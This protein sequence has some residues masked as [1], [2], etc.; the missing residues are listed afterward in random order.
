MLVL[1]GKS[2]VSAVAGTRRPRRR[3]W[4][5]AVALSL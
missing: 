2:Y 4:A 5:P 1:G 3:V